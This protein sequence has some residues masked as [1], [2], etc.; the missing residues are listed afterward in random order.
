[1]AKTSYDDLRSVFER[2]WRGVNDIDEGG[3]GERAD[4]ADIAKLRR[5]ATYIGDRGQ[6]VDVTAALTIGAFRDLYK[7]VRL[8]GDLAQEECLVVAAVTLA[9]VRVDA[10]GRQT[11]Q[12]LA[13][14]DPDHKVMSETRFLH[15]MRVRTPTEL[16]GAGRRVA[17]LLKAGAPVGDLGAS[18][19]VWLDDPDR[20]RI[21]AQAYYGLGAQHSTIETQAHTKI[22]TGAP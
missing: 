9:H 18:L 6:R 20:R 2:W 14:P 19:M 5:I 11:A 10:P 12:L 15:L 17:A 7:R 21:W 1:M 8:N 3:R 13:G 22:E 16:M 4:R